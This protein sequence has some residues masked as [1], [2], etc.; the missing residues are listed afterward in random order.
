MIGAT[1]TLKRGGSLTSE[2]YTV[3]GKMT[4]GRFDPE[5]GPVDIDLG[6][7]PESSYISRRHAQV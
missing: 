4:I 1:L 3:N 5:S 6:P 2:K 7:L